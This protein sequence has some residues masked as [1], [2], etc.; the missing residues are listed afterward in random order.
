MSCISFLRKLGLLPARRQATDDEIASASAENALR[1]NEAAF[2]QMHEA[3]SRVPESNGRLRESIKR[4][5]S[6]FADLENL[7]HGNVRQ[8]ARQ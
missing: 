3:Y 8:R 4:S 6:P 1:E 5:S 7:M 2:Q